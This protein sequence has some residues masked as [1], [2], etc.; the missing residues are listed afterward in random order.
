MKLELKMKRFLSKFFN[1]YPR[2]GQ[3]FFRIVNIKKIHRGRP[4]KFE[5]KNKEYIIFKAQNSFYVLLNQCPH[6][7]K[8]L[9]KSMISVDHLIC[10]HHNWKFDIQNGEYLNNPDFKLQTHETRIIENYLWVKF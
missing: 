3:N 7:Q 4:F 2:D 10:P 6:Q 1:V 9:E 5:F 8:S